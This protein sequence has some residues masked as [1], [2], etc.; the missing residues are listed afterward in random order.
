MLIMIAQGASNQAIATR[1][2]I[3]PQTVKNSLTKLFRR[4]GVTNRFQAAAWWR[5]RH[6]ET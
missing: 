4:L 6:V 3:H 5:D 2:G 1:L